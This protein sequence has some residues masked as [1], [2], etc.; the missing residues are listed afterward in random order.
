MAGNPP[1]ALGPARALFVDDALIGRSRGLRR[2]WHPLRK[3]LSRPVLIPLAPW[4]GTGLQ[5]IGLVRRDPADGLFKMWYST[6]TGNGQD[7]L[8]RTLVCYATSIDGIHWDRPSLGIHSF[9][10]V[11]ENNIIAAPCIPEGTKWRFGPFSNTVNPHDSRHPHKA[12]VFS[13]NADKHSRRVRHASGT[14]L[15]TSSDG[16]HWRESPRPLWYLADGFGDGPRLAYDA[17]KRRYI[18]FLKVYEDSEGRPLRR[19]VAGGVLKSLIRDKNDAWVE[20][21]RHPNLVRRRAVTLTDDLVHWSE[22]RYILPTDD[23]DAPGDQTYTHVAWPYES[24]YLGWLTMYHTRTRG[25]WVAGSQH[26]E[27][28]FSRDGED[29]HRPDD[30]TVMLPPG[31]LDRDWD[32]GSPFFMS[33]SP[34]IRVGDELWFYYNSVKC[35]HAPDGRGDSGFTCVGLATI[36]VDGFASMDAPRAGG[37]LLMRPMKA[38]GNRLCLNA[39]AGGGVAVGRILVEIRD[40]AGRPLRGRRFADCIP[41]DRDAA[42][43]EVTWRAKAAAIC[44]RVVRLAFKMNSASL[45]SVWTEP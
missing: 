25:R 9:R 42:R 29:W 6:G 39:D 44:G 23:R 24:M 33:Q 41:V 2:K 27:A 18:G 38:A 45:Y 13:F 8:T 37:T 7:W 32:Y 20:L 22:P 30:R 28:I 12:L 1:A 34:P 10:G 17:D 15:M 31:M 14:Y 11:R 16:L 3:P 40:V 36:R 21:A 5:A 43:I 26:I 4:E 35:L 19:Q